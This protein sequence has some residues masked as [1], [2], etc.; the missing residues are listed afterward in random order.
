MLVKKKKNDEDILNTLNSFTS[1][2]NDTNIKSL[3]ERTSP[4]TK[5]YNANELKNLLNNA[6]SSRKSAVS[7][8]NKYLGNNNV[9]SNSQNPLLTP[10]AKELRDSKDLIKSP[11]N[12]RNALTDE[13][14]NQQNY[15][16]AIKTDEAKSLL[17]DVNEKKVASGLLRG[18]YNLEAAK[19]DVAN[20][21]NFDTLLKTL[22]SPLRGI[23]TMFGHDGALTYNEKGEIVK[24]KSILQAQSDEM[25]KLGGATGFVNQMG[26]QLGKQSVQMLLN[27]LIP[28]TGNAAYFSTLANDVYDETKREGYNDKQ[29]YLYTALNTASEYFVG[30]ALGSTIGKYSKSNATEKTISN[31]LKPLIKN[32]EVNKTLSTMTAEGLE[33]FVQEYVDVAARNISL[34]EDN[35]I[36]FDT[37]KN[38]LYSFGLGAASSG[39]MSA[40][41][42]SLKTKSQKNTEQ[43]AYDISRKM[44]KDFDEST[45]ARIIDTIKHQ[46]E[47]GNYNQENLINQLSKENQVIDE[48]VKNKIGDKKVNKKE[49]SKIREE[50]VNNLEKG[51]TDL[52]DI[53]N[54][55]GG[56]DLKNFNDYNDLLN[57]YNEINGKTKKSSLDNEELSRLYENMSKYDFDKLKTNLLDKINIDEDSLLYNSVRENGNKKIAYKNDL[58]LYDKNQQK[59]IKNAIDSGILNNSRKTHD[60]VDMIAK[61]SSDK[62]VTFD[63]T[64]NKKLQESGFALK[65]KQVN[66][67]INN[68]K[69]TINIESKNA[70]NSVVGHEV[71]HVLEG[72][73]LYAELQQAV[74]EYATTK[75]DY[76]SRLAETTE[77]YKNIKG[78][79]IENELTSDLIGEYIFTDTDFV[80]SLSTTKPNIFQKIYNE[81]KY[82]YKLATAGSK[83]A[84]QLE[85]VKKTFEEAYR[86]SN[87]YQEN[88]KYS[89]QKD[90]NGNKYV[91][92][93]TDQDIFEGKSLS[94]QTKIAKQYILQKYREEGIRVNTENIEITSKTA[95]EYTHPK[96]QLPAAIKSSKMKASTELDNLLLIS[97]YKYSMPDDGRHPFAKDGWDYYET[98][99]DVGNNLF[100]GL[101]NIAKSGNKK[102]LYDI[103]KIKRIG[104]NRSTSANAF[105]TSLANSLNN[106]ISQYNKTVKSDISTKYSMQENANNTQELNNSSFLFQKNTDNSIKQQDKLIREV[107]PNYKPGITD[108]SSNLVANNLDIINYNTNYNNMSDKQLGISNKEKSYFEE[109]YKYNLDI[110]VSVDGGNTYFED[111]IKGLN[112]YHAIERAKRNYPSATN[113]KIKDKSIQVKNYDN[114]RYSMT[115]KKELDNSSFSLNKNAKQYDELTKTNYIDYFRKDNGDVKVY[116]MDSNNNLVNELSLWSNTNA[117]NEFGENLGNKIYETA[118][119]SSQRIEIG[120]DINNLGAE[121]DY[122]MNHRPSEGYGNASNFEENMPDVFEHPEWYLNLDEKYNRESLN[123]LKKVRN[124][125]NAELTI[126][127]ATIGNKINPGDWVTPSKA[128]AEYHNNS[129]F[130]GKGNV[131]EM[132]V[133]AKDIQ[134]AGDDI[135]EF[136]YFPNTG[137]SLANQNKISPKNSNLTYSDDVKINTDNKSLKNEIENA[138]KSVKKINIKDIKNLSNVKN[139]EEKNLSPVK[140]EQSAKI[141]SKTP[142]D[143]SKG[144]IKRGINIFRAAILDKGS[145]FEDLAIKSKNRQLMAT[146]DST[147]TSQAKAQNII[148][149][150]YQKFNSETKAIEKLSKSLYE[151]QNEVVNSGNIED[152][153]NYIYHKHNIDRMNLKS[154]AETE[155]STFENNNHDLMFKNK[156]SQR[157]YDEILELSKLK[158]TTNEKE[159]NLISAA[160]EYIKLKEKYDK[161][162]NKPVFGNDVTAEISQELVNEYENAHPEFIDYA[163]DI[164]DYLKAQKQTL[165]DNGIISQETSDL[166]N[167]M[168]PHYVP[169]SRVNEN[170]LK[171]DVPLKRTGTNSPVKAATGGN[172]DILPL[173]DT[174]ADRTFQTQKA[175]DKNK[176]GIEL[177]NSLDTT[178]EFSNVD[179]DGLIN[180]I[181]NQEN[182][183]KEGTKEKLP[184][185]TVFKDGERITYA[186]NQDM[187]DALS[188]I[189]SNS[190]LNVNSK[191]LNKL[192]SFQRGV[193]TEYNPVFMITN[194]VKDAQD[195][196]INSQHAAKTYSKFLEAQKQIKNKG[197]YY[198]EYM[199]SG[200]EQNTYFD[201]KTKVFDTKEDSKL[202]KIFKM[203]LEKISEA[204][205]FIEMTPRLAEYIASRESGRSVEVSMLDAARVTTNFK[206]G[207]DV[208]K[209]INRNGGTF[210]N[211]SVQGFNQQ[212]R[213]F[214]EANANGIR[215]YAGLALKFA[216]ASL[217]VIALNDLV[218]KDDDDYEE[219]LSDY[220]KQNYYVVF[221]YGDGKYIR[222][223]KG[224]TL[225]VIQNFVEQTES[226]VKKT[227]EFDVNEFINMAIDNLAPNNPLENNVISPLV[228]AASNKTWYGTDLVP[229]RLQNKPAAEQ[230][231][232]SI[233]EISKWLGKTFNVSPYKI[234]Y[235]MN[236]YSGG[237]GDVIMPMLTPETKSGNNTLLEYALSPLVDKFT[238]D[239]VMNNKNTGN[240]YET[241]EKLTINANKSNATNEDILKNKFVNS[242][243]SEMNDLYKEKREIQNSNISKKEKYEKV[244]GIQNQINEMSKYALNNYSDVKIDGNYATIGTKEYRLKTDSDGAESWTKITDDQKNKQRNVSSALGI[245][246]SE[247]WSNKTEYDYAYDNPGKYATIT[248]ITDYDTYTTYSKEISNIKSDKDSKGNSITDSRKKKVFAYINNLDLEF[249]QKVILAKMQYPS[250]NQYNNEILNYLNKNNDINYNEKV[251]ILKQLGFIVDENGKVRW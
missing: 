154:K 81:I 235:I 60:F 243:K 194:A 226:V 245:T 224:R 167:E 51:Y 138:D 106:N 189:S 116:L 96:N 27:S 25:A 140:G 152:F 46:K 182:L 129:Q 78:A 87:S 93:D 213:N 109:K 3:E 73:K 20:D 55:L 63:F 1:G 204:N 238:A 191:F 19:E 102:T 190:V 130:D 241:S 57:K 168:Y 91:K 218:W 103:T 127:R 174:L 157:S 121:T 188:P 244:R 84:R 47:K 179:V 108:I 227:G 134:F 74:K 119:D 230:Y 132:K 143:T 98:T 62:N 61:I 113:I 196:L 88:I 215:G 5:T 236:Q 6:E 139:K 40:V 89:I 4:T 137:Y 217:P 12:T 53:V 193:L 171:I 94:E 242:M 112:L 114:I 150:G 122:F 199:A 237:V 34:G 118:T 38:A 155:L 228:Q 165:V 120:N 26:D 246:A 69:I 223:P 185:F 219:E 11:I 126:Y 201:Y 239:S 229:T 9:I 83:E 159:N 111:S 163:S 212:V 95:N 133:K 8:F 54:I 32:A 177:M 234:N 208:T 249:E 24:G 184:T 97:N 248:S 198:Q 49:E 124:N 147:M 82:L 161:T 156:N 125:P 169:I 205:D 37:F 186:I 17:N 158:K 144:S 160:K 180:D 183:L 221:K 65:D 151:I 48:L 44:N 233:D 214:R 107:Y 136:G 207:G 105:S 128:Y 23:A 15:R 7:N 247:Y 101:I 79:N 45:N 41:D 141:L 164:Y 231:D 142:I 59:V 211:A 18:K 52:D 72:S 100:K 56:K 2:L 21:S 86:Q 67:F 75:G 16:N 28:G 250:Y 148:G 176:F 175:I 170:N 68:D 13:L 206:A 70:L 197:Y 33:E 71:T 50:I 76:E 115:S 36:D 35:K 92:I 42:T 210:L 146:W 178:T 43:E 149:D 80:N 104:Q 202:K 135:N 225:S 29:A 39:V 31:I 181:D 192:S 203:P 131:L 240:L 58:N 22:S 173:F 222:I 166:W 153:S 172:S 232:E 187:Y 77:L 145:V 123:A 216:V 90:T 162:D 99:F 200:G 195:V 251:L 66:G 85:K 30:K 64:N 110:F 220:V 117:T 10:T 14:Q 209:W